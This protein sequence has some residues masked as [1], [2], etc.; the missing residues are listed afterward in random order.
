M[1]GTYNGLLCFQDLRNNPN[2]YKSISQVEKSHQD[3]VYDCFWSK[4]SKTGTECI[5]TSTDGRILWWDA[6][7][8]DEPVDAF[9]MTETN[10]GMKEG[11][12]DK[13]FGGLCLE[14]NNEQPTKYLVGTEQGYVL[15]ANKRPKK[16]VEISQR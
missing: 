6:R 14:H 11:D 4:T 10:S 13:V 8:M 7:K 3:P 9:L 12:P 15:C 16:A 1:G 2:K 5:S